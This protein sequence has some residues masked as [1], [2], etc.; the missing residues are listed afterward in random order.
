MFAH[1]PRRRPFFVGKMASGAKI[2][3]A[4]PEPT[5][6][7]E[8]ETLRSTLGL[9]PALV[10]QILNKACEELGLDATYPNLQAKADACLEAAGVTALAGA[11]SQAPK[12]SPALPNPALV[13]P[14][15]PS[16]PPQPMFPTSA[17]LQQQADDA[18]VGR[19]ASLGRAAVLRIAG[20]Q[21]EHCVHQ[22]REAIAID[23][24]DTTREHAQGM[25]HRWLV[26]LAARGDQGGLAAS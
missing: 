25:G 5:L 26:A 10:P 3:P 19:A 7:D 12:V 1:S 23:H 20:V 17:M 21:A 16:S 11:S 24:V 9:D 8:V 14:P 22:R 13:Q 18:L 6:A 4:P 15:Q 2:A